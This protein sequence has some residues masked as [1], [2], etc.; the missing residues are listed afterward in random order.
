MSKRRTAEPVEAQN[1]N[2][3]SILSLSFAQAYKQITPMGLLKGCAQ[4][5]ERSTTAN[6]TSC[7]QDE[8]PPWN[9]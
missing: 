8:M 2:P 7:L 6:Q 4:T 5:I 1:Q 9:E 3:I